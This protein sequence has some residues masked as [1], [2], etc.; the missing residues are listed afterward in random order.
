MSPGLDAHPVRRR[1]KV[2]LLLTAAAV[3]LLLAGGWAVGRL[4]APQPS[5]P[6][7]GGAEAGFARDMQ[8]HHSQAVEMSML[9]R[10]RTD[11]EEIRRL[12]YDIAVTQQQQAGQMHG[13]LSVWGLPQS[14]TQPPMS[15]MSPTGTGSHHA[16]ESPGHL[17]GSS[18][19]E[20]SGP[21]GLM[22]G[23]ASPADLERLKAARGTSAE[24]IYLE[25]MI[26][27]HEAAVIMAEAVLARSTNPAVV[28]LAQ[29]IKA[30]QQSEIDY[31][32]Q[33]LQNR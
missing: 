1:N 29:S 8:V 3:L 25:L 11:D 31:L 14:S 28:D 20:S 2:R 33:L 4:S 16:P 21:A 9:I 17:S 18:S 23:M 13:W 26:P 12:A 27:H 19:G 5:F 32:K 6:L 22:P 10:D 24:R 7:D 30:S 15:W